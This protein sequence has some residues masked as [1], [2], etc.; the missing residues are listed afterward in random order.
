V[1]LVVKGWIFFICSYLRNKSKN[2]PSIS[3]PH[4]EGKYN[5]STVK[6]AE[7]GKHR[8]DCI[9]NMSSSWL[10]PPHQGSAMMERA[11]DAR[12]QR[13]GANSSSD[14]NGKINGREDEH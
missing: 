13:E 4:I 5:A 8:I 9:D 7:E 10:H 12:H 11:T 3:G 6:R 2:N 14:I 1:I